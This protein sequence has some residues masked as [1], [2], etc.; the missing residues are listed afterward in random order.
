M[1]PLRGTWWDQ[2]VRHGVGSEE[3]LEKG[4]RAHGAHAPVK[5][6]RSTCHHCGET[7]TRYVNQQIW[8]RCPKCK[9]TNMGLTMIRDYALTD[10]QRSLELAAAVE[11]QEAS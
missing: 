2:R 5:K 3:Q 11:L 10:A 9:R 6:S 4:G 1:T 7:S 8:W